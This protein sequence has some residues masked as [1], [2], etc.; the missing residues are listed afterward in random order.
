MDVKEETIGIARAFEL[1][2]PASL[3]LVILKGA[4]KRLQVESG[5]KF[6]LKLDELGRIIY[7]PLRPRTPTLKVEGI[8][9]KT[10]ISDRRR[11]ESAREN[12]GGP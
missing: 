5:E 10:T 8:H 7:E 3:V 9:A 6:Y 4:R 1:G 12:E 2:S 11:S